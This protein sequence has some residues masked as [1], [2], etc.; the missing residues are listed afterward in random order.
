MKGSEE[1]DKEEDRVKKREA[2]G[3]PNHR[4][5]LNATPAS[6]TRIQIL[7][8]VPPSHNARPQLYTQTLKPPQ[9]PD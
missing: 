9:P 8:S 5:R 1:E 7:Q 6:Q 3:I 2:D 4:A